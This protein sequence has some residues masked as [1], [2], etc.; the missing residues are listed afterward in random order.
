M[1]IKETLYTIGK[2]GLSTNG[3]WFV[4][5]TGD[6]PEQ[7]GLEFKTGQLFFKDLKDALYFLTEQTLKHEEEYKKLVEK[8]KNQVNLNDLDNALKVQKMIKEFN[9]PKIM[10]Q[11]SECLREEDRLPKDWF[12]KEMHTAT[13]GD[14]IGN[15]YLCEKC[16]IGTNL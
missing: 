12:T 10:Y 13:C 3:M 8:K 15:I 9:K 2:I 6:V 1:A 7:G 5:Y 4:N 16:K 14:Y 11:C